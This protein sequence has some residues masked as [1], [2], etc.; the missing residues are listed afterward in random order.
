[1]PEIEPVAQLD[2]RFSTPGGSSPSWAEVVDV[3][4]K[5]EMFWLSTA[6]SN[7]RPHLTPLP[8]IWHRGRLHICTGDK[9]QKAKNLFAEPRCSLATGTDRMNSGLDVVVEGTVE[10][11]TDQATSHE[12]AEL[13]KSELA[14]DFSVRDGGFD[15]GEGRAALSAAGSVPSPTRRAAAARPRRRSARRLPELPCARGPRTA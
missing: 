12:L 2:Q 9:E 3:L 5:S 14:W 11:I 7:G 10:R 8:A 1:M 4:K 13:W 6:R 15:D